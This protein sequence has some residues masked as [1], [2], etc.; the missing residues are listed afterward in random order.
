MQPLK[1]RGQRPEA[2]IQRAI[3][4]KLR[5]N[6]WYV[7]ATHGNAFSKGW[8]DLYATHSKYGARWIEV[9]LPEMKG[10]RYT[11]AQLEDF[12]KFCANGAGIWVL[13]GD[14]DSEMLKLFKPCNWY[15]YI[16]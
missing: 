16:R 14:S 6:G 4:T 13:T 11:A 7:R 10:S 9:K 3:I 5:Y 8:A 15:Q 2:K 1:L 12:P